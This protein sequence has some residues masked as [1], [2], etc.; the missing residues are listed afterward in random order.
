[1]R[2]FRVMLLL[3]LAGC[4]GGDPTVPSTQ[5]PEGDADADT[6]TD[7]DADTDADADAD[8]DSDA[9]TD[10]DA[11]T[12]TDADADADADG[13]TDT[14]DAPC[15]GPAAPQTACV[16]LD[17]TDHPMD[18]FLGAQLTTGTFG[19]DAVVISFVGGP[20]GQPWTGS[21]EYPSATPSNTVLPCTTTGVQIETSVAGISYRAAADLTA[22]GAS[23][24]LTIT[25]NADA[26][27]AVI[28]GSFTGMVLPQGAP[29]PTPAHG[30]WSVPV[31][32]P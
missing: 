6:D 25:T 4:K 19:T 26:N 28:E 21:I 8:A 2:T 15:G 16:N 20:T 9:D 22:L 18:L 3:L 14:G 12:D 1:M 17:G 24:S 10:A 31:S 11:D 7:S 30:S 29:V 5:P 32:V 13:D 27:G 23:C